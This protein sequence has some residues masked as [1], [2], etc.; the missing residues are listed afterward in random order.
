M[1]YQFIT[2]NQNIIIAESINIKYAIISTVYVFIFI[3]SKYVLNKRKENKKGP[4]NIVIQPRIFL[5]V[6]IGGILIFFP[7]SLIFLFF[8]ENILVDYVVGDN[9][10]YFIFFLIFCIPYFFFIL[11]LNWKIEVL[12]NTFVYRNIFRIKKTY[13]YS[14]IGIRFYYNGLILHY[15]KKRVVKI[16]YHCENFDAIQSAI[17]PYIYVN[18]KQIKK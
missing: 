4:Q 18:D 13:N 5:Y 3:L 2:Y 7:I 10:L 1:Y 8:S 16:S 14:E 12:E 17:A 15:K 11:Q 6:G 9:V